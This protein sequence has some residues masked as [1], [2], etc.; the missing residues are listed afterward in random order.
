MHE[1][2]VKTFAESKKEKVFKESEHHFS[3]CVKEPAERNMA[4]KRVIEL[5]AQEYGVLENQVRIL[6]GHHRPN[7]LLLVSSD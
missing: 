3:I 1:V 2:R 5:I 6:T 4:N 7:K